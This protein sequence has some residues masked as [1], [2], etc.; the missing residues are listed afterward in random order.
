MQEERH[1]LRNSVELLNAKPS[2][3]DFIKINKTVQQQ[4]QNN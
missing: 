2:Y 4:K 3:K 1:S